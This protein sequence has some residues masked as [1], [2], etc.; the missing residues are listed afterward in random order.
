MSQ[1]PLQSIVNLVLFSQI[2][3]VVKLELQ[4]SVPSW[5]TRSPFFFLSRT[6]DEYSVI[7][8]KSVIPPEHR[9]ATDWRCLKVAGDISPELPGVAVG[10]SKPMADAGLSLI[11]VGTHDRDYILVKS[12]LLQAGRDVYRAAGFSVVE[13]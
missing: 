10:V 6:D 7:C 1:V 13:S 11:L 2:F 9:S 8:E 3:D 4:Q 12:E 5:I